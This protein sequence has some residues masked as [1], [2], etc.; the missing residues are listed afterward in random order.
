MREVKK[1][2]D[3]QRRAGRQPGAALQH[4]SSLGV[5][6][7]GS[8][9]SSGHKN[10]I[11]RIT[12][13]QI[14]SPRGSIVPTAAGGAL[15]HVKAA[16]MPQH[17]SNSQMKAFEARATSL[18]KISSRVKLTQFQVLDKKGQ[19]SRAAL[20]YKNMS[21]WDHQNL[22]DVKGMLEKRQS[23]NE[24]MVS[25]SAKR[26]PGQLKDLNASKAGLN[27]SPASKM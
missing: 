26:V 6:F 3:L 9:D 2:V 24:S 22:V 1:E 7:Q 12:A 20:H 19:N 5:P 4:R 27:N 10:A 23:Q 8:I 21:K 11:D 18:P 15:T 16:T 13:A 25:P 14:A 17:A